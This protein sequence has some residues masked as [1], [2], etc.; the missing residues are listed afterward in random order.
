MAK[1]WARITVALQCMETNAV[2]YHTEINKTNT[3]ELYLMKYCKKLGK[4][5]KHKVREKLK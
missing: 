5:T 1:K 4:R 3:S 2:N